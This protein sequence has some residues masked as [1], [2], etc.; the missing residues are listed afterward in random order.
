MSYMPISPF[1][2]PISHTHLKVIETRAT[3][4]P[5]SVNKWKVL[6]D[7]SKA[8]A[9]FG[10]NVR[11][12]T[13][14]QALL[15]FHPEDDIGGAPTIVFPSNKTICERLHGMP[16]STMRRHLGRLI[17]AG[18]ISR[19][20]SPTGKRY[21]RKGREGET[22]FGFDLCPLNREADQI[23]KAADEARE[24]E[25][26]IRH[27]REAIS[28]MRRDINALIALGRSEVPALSLWDRLEDAVALTG[29]TLR[30]KLP[31]AELEHLIADY[32]A[33]I[34]EAQGVLSPPPAVDLDTDDAQNEQ[35]HL[36]SNKEY[37]ESELDECIEAPRQPHAIRND[38]EKALRLPLSLVTSVCH[39]LRSFYP[40]K[41]NS[42]NELFNA[43][44]DLRPA[45]GVS[46]HA[47]QEA[48]AK[49]GKDIAAVTLV[50]MLERF[51]E[52]RNPS[53]YLRALAVKAT[54]NTFSPA[55]MIMALCRERKA[56]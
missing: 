1:M 45:M 37:Q 40:Q 46:M 47:W 16:C 5:Y 20:D 43:A 23:A 31:A 4:L 35:R 27:K 53:G 11:D 2:R 34:S 28:L 14:L 33:M 32:T 26:Q 17:D 3:P 19:K 55:P 50:A 13:V 24:A 44:S 30:R 38:A 48:T 18:L 15:S 10:I 29:R 49:M 42:W 52:I 36:S 39:S 54:Q 7:L 51:S 9:A 12:L 41:V 6:R 22:A 25:S 56:A 21:L 8:Q